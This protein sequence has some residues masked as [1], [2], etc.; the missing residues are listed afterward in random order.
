MRYDE[1]QSSQPS[2]EQLAAYADGELDGPARQA[3]ENWL[4]DHPDAAQEVEQHRSLARAWNDSS[5][6]EPSAEAWQHTLRNIQQK[7]QPRTHP[8]R[9]RWLGVILAGLAAAGILA[10]LVA[11]R[12]FAPAPVSPH[13]TTTSVEP[14]EEPFPVVEAHEVIVISMNPNDG[15]ALVVAEPLQLSD[16]QL[17]THEDIEIIQ[18]ANPQIKLDDW[19]TPMI[20][21]PLAFGE[22]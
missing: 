9:R 15:E 19:G 22:K 12:F 7:L 16:M 18:Q 2:P 8:T 4:T 14:A 5:A 13:Q 1:R 6:P 20:V 10:A 21:D 3:V 17:V 11:P